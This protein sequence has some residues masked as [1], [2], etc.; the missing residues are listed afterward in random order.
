[1]YF[2]HMT[3][4]CVSKFKISFSSSGD[5]DVVVIHDAVRP[6]IDE[7][8]IEQVVRAA[9]EHGVCILL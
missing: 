3:G 2:I 6:D 4:V 7:Q 1:M 9:H 5:T 8:V